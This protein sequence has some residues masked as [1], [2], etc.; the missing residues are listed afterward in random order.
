MEFSIRNIVK[1]FCKHE[2]KNDKCI[3][4]GYVR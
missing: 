2:Y 3:K 4:C 1:L